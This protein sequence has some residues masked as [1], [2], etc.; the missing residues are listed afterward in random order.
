MDISIIMSVY[1]EPQEWLELSVESILMQTYT[2]FELIIIVDDPNNLDAIAYLK[3]KQTEDSRII[4][5]KNQ[6]NIGLTKSLNKGIAASKGKYIARMDADDISCI[7]RLE[8]QYQYMETHPDIDLLGSYAILFGDNKESTLLKTPIEHQDIIKTLQFKQPIPHP[9]IIL[10]KSTLV[11]KNISY[12]ENLRR[13]QDLCLFQTMALR[14]CKFH[15]LPEPLIKYRISEKQISNRDKKGQL[16]DNLRSRKFIIDEILSTIN[17]PFPQTVSISY[18]RGIHQKMNN[19]IENEFAKSLLFQLYLSVPKSPKKALS[20][21]YDMIKYKFNL[22]YTLILLMSFFSNRW[23]CYH[24]DTY[25][26]I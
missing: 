26:R 9:S 10:R 13:A 17:E 20:F 21:V 4:I 12:N 23:N 7:D 22:H 2:N 11:N 19:I 24:L 8:K 1:Q 3:N 25:K 6:K 18:V 5:I 15:C 14:R 16:N